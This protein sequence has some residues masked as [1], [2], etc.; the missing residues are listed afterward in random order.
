[1]VKRGIFQ[2]PSIDHCG[3]KGRPEG[4][5]LARQ[6]RSLPL[7]AFSKSSAEEENAFSPP[8]IFN[9]ALSSLSRLSAPPSS[10]Y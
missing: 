8:R 7:A 10:A 5:L 3:F 2:P 6:T 9:L 1:M 4:E